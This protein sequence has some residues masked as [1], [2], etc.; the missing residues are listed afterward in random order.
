[1]KKKVLIITQNFYPAIGSAGGNRMKNIFQL[2]LKDNIDVEV[3]T[4]EPS[5]PPNKNMYKDRMFWDDEEVN[6][7]EQRITRIPIKNKRFSNE[8]FSRLF[9]I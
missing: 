6:N 7:Q 5:Y 4:I 3:L 9:F 8:L 2:L 1:M